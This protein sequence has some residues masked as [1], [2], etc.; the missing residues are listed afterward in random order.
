MDFP[1][2]KA[3]KMVIFLISIKNGIFTYNIYIKY[4]FFLGKNVL[5]LIELLASKVYNV[6][7]YFIDKYT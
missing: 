3:F 1:P 7:W 5:K 2:A 4:F 6:Y